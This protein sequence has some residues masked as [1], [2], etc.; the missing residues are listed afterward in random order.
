MAQSLKGSL[1]ARPQNQRVQIGCFTTDWEAP[2]TERLATR[3]LGMGGAE[4]EE[5]LLGF[6]SLFSFTSARVFCSVLV[7]TG[8]N[9]QEL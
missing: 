8:R 3:S 4:V 7:G 6:C 2:S 1:G 9:L 5:F